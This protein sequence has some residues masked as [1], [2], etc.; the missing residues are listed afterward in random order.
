MYRS[1]FRAAGEPRTSIRTRALAARSLTAAPAGRA[2]E[3]ARIAVT[4]L[5]SLR[6]PP[7]R[8]MLWSAPGTL[9]GAALLLSRLRFVPRDCS[10]ALIIAALLGHGILTWILAAD[11]EGR[12]RAQREAWRSR[13][14]TVIEGNGGERSREARIADLEARMEAQDALL[15][16]Y[17]KAWAA[18]APQIERPK[19]L[20]VVPAEA[21]EAR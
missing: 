5:R 17:G 15:H 7:G 12:V 14:G 1:P 8:I 9:M 18:I 21:Q 13:G 19:H 6:I 10:D 16:A 2:R 11:Q 3:A 4:W 20:A